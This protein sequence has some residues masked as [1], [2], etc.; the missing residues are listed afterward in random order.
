MSGT[1]RDV[2]VADNSYGGIYYYIVYVDG[3][4]YDRMDSS[5]SLTWS[6]QAD[7]AAGYREALSYYEIPGP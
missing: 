4:P 2:Y 6:Q 5:V 7:I 3:Q 1:V